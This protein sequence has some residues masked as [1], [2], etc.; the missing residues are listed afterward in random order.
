MSNG[1]CIVSKY[2]VSC[3]EEP[4]CLRRNTV[5]EGD[6]PSPAHT[7]GAPTATASSAFPLSFILSLD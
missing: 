7:F 5:C 1:A 3:E 4:C 2:R 6:K